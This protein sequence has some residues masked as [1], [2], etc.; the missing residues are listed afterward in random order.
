M[1][2]CLD[3]AVQ[4]LIGDIDGFFN[5][6]TEALRSL[7][8]TKKQFVNLIERDCDGNLSGPI[9]GHVYTEHEL[10]FM[11]SFLKT[12]EL[13]LDQL[14]D[15]MGKLDEVMGVLGSIQG[16]LD[17]DESSILYYL[18]QVLNGPWAC[19][20]FD[21]SSMLS[22]NFN[23]LQSTNNAIG[24][25]GN[26]VRSNISATVYGLEPVN[27]ALDLYNHLPPKMQ[28]NIG[29]GIKTATNVF[30]F[31]Q[32]SQVYNDQTLPYI[33]KLPGLRVNTEWE[34]GFTN[35]ASGNLL[36]K[37]VSFFNTL[38]NTSDAVFGE[39]ENALGFAAN[40][41]F[42]FQKL[43]N[44]FAINAN[45]AFGTLN[46]VNRLLVSLDTTEST[47]TDKII[48]KK[49]E[50]IQ[51][52]V[53]G[54]VITDNNTFNQQMVTRDG[55]YDLYT[56]DG[57]GGLRS[58][59]R[60]RITTTISTEKGIDQYETCEEATNRGRELGC[61]GCH[62]H[63]TADGQVFFMPCNSMKEYED[64]ISGKKEP[65]C[66]ADRGCDNLKF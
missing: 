40:K 15:F 51:T 48:Q 1:S 52:N 61:E 63:T 30:N 17:L 18:R 31:N 43:T 37:D 26:A 35:L 6:K 27:A 36:L 59:P 8:V 25:L 24:T 10:D 5:N 32:E 28:E 22:G 19:A 4:G 29:N 11:D 60:R 21:I 41:I 38:K 44:I 65:D 2:A 64:I 23:I 55:S 14:D 20:A 16:V 54:T 57:Q 34:Q 50:Q 7:F 9:Q 49:C 47:T 46:A 66:D 58:D 62:T 3:Q 39:I 13:G 53:F 45:K 33:D 42:Q 12:F 56:L